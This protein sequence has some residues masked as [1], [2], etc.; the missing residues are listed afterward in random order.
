MKKSFALLF[1]AL[2][3]VLTFVPA[4][5]PPDSE[6]VLKNAPQSDLLPL[7]FT[8]AGTFDGLVGHVGGAGIPLLWDIAY[9]VPSYV[10][11]LTGPRSPP[12]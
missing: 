11:S 1:L 8:V 3:L 2:I 12:A 9:Y 5:I 6:T 7:L 10:P 4:Y